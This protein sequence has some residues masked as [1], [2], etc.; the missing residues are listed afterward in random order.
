MPSAMMSA[1][2][3]S[4]LAH[5]VFAPS[6]VY[7]PS[8]QFLTLIERMSRLPVLQ[9]LAAGIN[10]AVVV[11]MSR[12]VFTLPFRN[13]DQVLANTPSFLPAARNHP[14]PGRRCILLDS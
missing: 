4:S 1:V 13:L 3:E 8:D 6:W 2:I 7:A 5:T 10:F 11:I 9:I 12:P 14:V